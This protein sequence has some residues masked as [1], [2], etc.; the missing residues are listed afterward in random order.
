MFT[1]TETKMQK[2]GVFVKITP[3]QRVKTGISGDQT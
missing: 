3:L 1:K 2:T